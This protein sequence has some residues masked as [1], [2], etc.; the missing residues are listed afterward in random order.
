MFGFRQL[1][2]IAALTAAALP[3]QAA[4]LIKNGSF[5]QPLAP[6]GGYLSFSPGDSFNHWLVV[7]DPGN[8]G[9]INED[10][11]YCGHMLNAKRGKQF[12]DLTGNTDNAHQTGVQ[13][14]IRTVAGSTYSVTFY[15]GNIVDTSSNCGTTSTVDLVV[16]GAPVATF[17][18]K[19][20]AGKTDIV[21]KKFSTEFVAQHGT[22]TLA[23]I[24]E[25]P[26]SDTAN[27]IDAVSVSLVA[28]P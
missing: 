15:L 28:A 10:L 21:W 3:A 23:F 12:V 24:N 14:T 2:G 20:G 11:Q 8:I 13:Q 22:T 27:G 19:A 16:D 1:V 4:N 9:L 6:D 25:D 5:E 18:N 7:G 26:P 17:T